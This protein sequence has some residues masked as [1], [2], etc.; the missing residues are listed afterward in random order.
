MSK[1]ISVEEYLSGLPVER[2]EAMRRLRTV[3]KKNLPK[4]FEECMA[5]GMIGY[6]VPH[7]LYPKGYHVDPNQPLGF[8]SIAS[9]KSH[10]A[11]YHMGLYGS[12]ELLNWFKTAY[13]A[14]GV[15]KL[16][17]G[18]SCIRFKHPDKIPFELVGALAK[19]LTPKAWISAYEAVLNR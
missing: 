14:A 6:V 16:D 13:A 19:K 11:L 15:G 5:Y 3:I 10:I 12:D 2:Q 7:S 17:M 4:G 18:K 1:A 9:Q 8:I